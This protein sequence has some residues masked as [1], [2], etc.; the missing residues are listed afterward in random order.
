MSNV[1]FG[2]IYSLSLGNT[3][4]AKGFFD[5]FLLQLIIPYVCGIVGLLWFSI[6]KAMSKTENQHDSFNSQN[7][8]LLDM[9][10]MEVINFENYSKWT[11]IAWIIYFIPLI[12]NIII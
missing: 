6:Y 12:Y 3:F 9:L 4:P 10:N 7:K 8:S 1:L 5:V 2:S 11:F